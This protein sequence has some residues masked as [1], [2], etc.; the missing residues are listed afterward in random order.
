MNIPA[1][2]KIGLHF[3]ILLLYTKYVLFLTL[4]ANILMI[5]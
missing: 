3:H 4:T 1:L 5:I 2:S